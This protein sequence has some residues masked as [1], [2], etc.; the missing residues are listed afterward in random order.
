M[1]MQKL[2]LKGVKNVLSRAEMKNIMAGSGGGGCR[3]WGNPCNV[4][5]TGMG[6]L[7]CPGVACVPYAGF[8]MCE[9]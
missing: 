4:G 8:G 1:K 7:C 2:S 3:S 5:E 9:A 6:S